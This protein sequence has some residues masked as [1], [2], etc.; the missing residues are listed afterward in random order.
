MHEIN[1][2]WVLW[3]HQ[4]TTL[5]YEQ[6]TTE[7]GK[8]KTLEEFWQYFNNYPFPSKLFYN[9]NIKPRLTNPVREISSISMF[10]ENIFPKWE[11]PNNTNG[12][13]IAIR[14]FTSM[15]QIDQIWE[16]VAIMCVGEFFA[17]ANLINGIRVV[18]SSIANKKKLYRVEIWFS[19]KTY[20]KEIENDLKINLG[21]ENIELFYKEHST[22]VETT[23]YRH[24]R[25]NQPRKSF[26]K[27]N[28]GRR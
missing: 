6:N 11:D 20:R 14:S 19:D 15:E 25:Y 21:V 8:F 3:E 7:L 9:N 5:N 18:D 28:N 22:A 23:P 24:K 4:N 1:N 26:N 27:G 2:T 16:T 12:G 17:N 13:D 10:K